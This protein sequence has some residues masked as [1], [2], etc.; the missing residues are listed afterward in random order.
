M[1]ALNSAKETIKSIF[2]I[3]DEENKFL[4]KNLKITPVQIEEAL[5]EI[6]LGNLTCEDIVYKNEKIISKKLKKIYH[7]N[8]EEIKKKS[9]KIIDISTDRILELYYKMDNN[10]FM[11]IAE[12]TSQ[13]I[14]LSVYYSA[15]A[16]EYDA[17]YEDDEYDDNHNIYFILKEQTA[18]S[19]I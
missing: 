11:R 9:Y 6:D 16:Y 1:S 8:L 10:A 15:N 3:K 18:N 12:K 7:E 19:F 14:G 2:K 17:D 4:N 13:Q 5:M